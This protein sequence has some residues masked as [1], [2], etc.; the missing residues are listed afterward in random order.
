MIRFSTRFLFT[1]NKKP[2]RSTGRCVG[3]LLT[4]WGTPTKHENLL[5]MSHIARSTLLD[6]L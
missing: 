6:Y 4:C 1:R 2:N 3:I 5:T